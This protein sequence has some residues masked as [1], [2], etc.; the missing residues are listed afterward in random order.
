MADR[1]FSRVRNFLITTVIHYVH[2]AR[3][4]HIDTV[5]IKKVYVMY[6]YTLVVQ[7]ITFEL[8]VLILHFVSTFTVPMPY[9]RIS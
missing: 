6:M 4:T 7:K 5:G 3:S 8:T 1:T 2:I 9:L